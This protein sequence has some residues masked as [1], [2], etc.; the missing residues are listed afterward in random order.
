M[1]QSL[2]LEEKMGMAKLKKEGESGLRPWA[3]SQKDKRHGKV[4]GTENTAAS[5]LLA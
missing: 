2:I 5:P 4:T 1:W 3:S